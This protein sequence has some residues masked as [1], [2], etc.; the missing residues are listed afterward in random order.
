MLAM[1][2]STETTH[3]DSHFSVEASE[4]ELGLRPEMLAVI[5]VTLA[6]SRSNRP[7]PVRIDASRA[8]NSERSSVWHRRLSSAASL[9]ARATRLCSSVP[10]LPGYAW[11]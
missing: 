2:P 5:S 11:A 6:S 8:I 9:T 10:L 7:L 1:W 4:L 3:S